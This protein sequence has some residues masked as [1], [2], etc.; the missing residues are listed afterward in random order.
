MADAPTTPAI[1]DAPTTPASPPRFDVFISYSRRDSAFALALYKALSSYRP[2]E[3]LGL[4]D[5]RMRVF[6]DRSDF[7]GVDYA[8]AI[9]RHLAESAKLIVICSPNA[10]QNPKYINEEIRSFVARRG[11]ANV[12]P[13]LLAGI[14][15][16]EAT[17]ELEAQLAFPQELCDALGMPLARDFRGFDGQTRRLDRGRFEEA[18]FFLLADI[19]DKSRSEIERRDQIRRARTQR[20]LLGAAGALVAVLSA[21]TV[22]AVVQRNTAVT[23]LVRFYQSNA[24]RRIEDRD[25]PGAIL[26]YTEALQLRDDELLRVRL[27]GLLRSYPRL[28][29]V[30]PAAMNGCDFSPDARRVACADGAA[31]ARVWDVTT[32][33]AMSPPLPTRGAI[34]MVSFSPNGS[35][36]LTADSTGETRVRDATSGRSIATLSLPA[37]VRQAR[38]TPAGD[39][40]VADALDGSMGVFDAATGR[41]IAP[42]MKHAFPLRIVMISG[43]GSRIATIINDGTVFP[44]VSVWDASTGQLVAPPVKRPMPGFSASFTSGNDLVYLHVAPDTLAVCSAV[45][46]VCRPMHMAPT[47]I[48]SSSFNADGSRLLIVG[49]DHAV[50]ALDV[51]TGEPIGDAMKHGPA[52]T[53]ALFT[54]NGDRILTFDYNHALHVWDVAESAEGR[55]RIESVDNAWLS[56]DGS[57]LAV[58]DDGVT[59]S[60]NVQ[61]LNITDRHEVT[62]PMRQSQAV[63]DVRFSRDGRYVLIVGASSWLWELA[64]N[65]F[66]QVGDSTSG[67]VLAAG[68]DGARRALLV[69]G[70]ERSVRVWDVAGARATTPPMQHESRIDAARMVGSKPYVI[71][72]SFIDRPGQRSTPVLTAWDGTTGQRVGSPLEGGRLYERPPLGSDDARVIVSMEDGSLRVWDLGTGATDGTRLPATIRATRLTSTGICLAVAADTSTLRISKSADGTPFGAVVRN[73]GRVQQVELSPDCAHV[74][75]I[76][77]DERLRIWDTRTGEFVV[78]R[79]QDDDGFGFFQTAV[80]SPDGA[81]VATQANDGTARVWS[82]ATGAPRTT[83][84]GSLAFITGVAFTA[85]GRYVTAVGHDMTGMMWDAATGERVAELAPAPF[86]LANDGIVAWSADGRAVVA[87]ANAYLEDVYTTAIV[88]R[89][90]D[91]EPDSRDVGALSTLAQLMAGRRIDASGSFVSLTR[92]ELQSLSAKMK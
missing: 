25:V 74:T 49:G 31:S 18:W 51:Q 8:E 90:H 37:A 43:D 3:G 20:R 68:F 27:A 57:R 36:L 1:A 4:P 60:G 48:E 76:D 81:W 15:N 29:R 28:V 87:A 22:T 10:R 80:F 56:P 41:A 5:Q 72:Q 67:R 83:P 26:W 82:A 21:L 75:T 11:A 73:A 46:S 92:A 38:F 6:I 88:V 13:V 9:V 42:L 34:T 16:N 55:A 45:S 33:T 50:R 2:P 58:R 86:T 84:L 63:R 7:T 40:V 61:V 64:P 39:R 91:L 24:Q 14:P 54:P 52:V 77:D 62:V 12:I 17:P 32:G 70:D 69:I 79:R 47:S 78:P 85:D 59:A 30:F 53:W 23:R 89:V 19:Y 35:M 71:T 44:T 66:E 65:A